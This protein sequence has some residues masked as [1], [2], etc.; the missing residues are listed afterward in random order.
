PRWQ[1]ICRTGTCIL[2]RERAPVEGEELRVPPPTTGNGSARSAGAGGKAAFGGRSGNRCG[3][4]AG[5][6]RAV[7][8]LRARAAQ[9]GHRFTAHDQSSGTTAAQ[10]HSDFEESPANRV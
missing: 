5:L 7:D 10:R 2:F 4:I 3:Q 1:R 9:K 8:P 6:S